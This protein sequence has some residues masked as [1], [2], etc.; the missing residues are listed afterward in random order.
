MRGGQAVMVA[1]GAVLLALPAPA[2]NG[3]RNVV[4]QRWET[5]ADGPMGG[6][7]VDM[8]NP[9]DPAERVARRPGA[10]SRARLRREPPPWFKMLQDHHLLPANQQFPALAPTAVMRQNGRL[11]LPNLDGGRQA[12]TLGNPN[13][14]L[15]FDFTPPAGDP[16]AH[17]WSATQQQA[18]SQF[19]TDIEAVCLR[20]YGPPAYNNTVKVVHDTSLSGLN[21][22][23]YD[24]T[25][26]EIRQELLFDVDFDDVTQSPVDP[27]DLYVLTLTV[28]KAY[29][30]DT[31]L[32]YEVW[33]DGLARAA[34]LLVISQARPE[35]SSYLGTGQSN[36]ARVMREALGVVRASLAQCAWLKVYAENPDVF[37][38][39]N[40]AYYSRFN[41]GLRGNVPILRSLIRAAVPQVEGF[42]FDD[43]YR[44]Q[45]VFDTAVVPGAKL[46]VF[47]HP[48]KDF[49]SFNQP[50]N[51]LPMNIYHFQV[52]SAN[53]ELPLGGQADIDYTA[54]DGVSLNNAVEGAN[55]PGALHTGIGEAGNTAG[56]GSV[57]PLFFN[58]AGDQQ[59]QMQRI[60]VLVSVNGLQRLIWYPND[61][62]LDDTAA[63]NHLA[64]L[65]TNGFQGT[66]DIAIE[67]KAP[68]QAQ[69]IQGAFK[70]KVPGGLPVP[71]RATLTWTPDTS[72]GSQGDAIVRNVMFL[73]PNGSGVDVAQGQAVLI[74]DTPPET[75]Q[76]LHQ[77]VAA[78]L[79]MITIPAFA[80]RGNEAGVLG[81]S[82]DQ[83]LMARAD[84]AVTTFQSYR[85]GSI[86]RLFPD[87]PAFRPGYAYWVKARS[88]LT[89]DFQG[90]TAN[91][92]RP[93]RQFFPPGW[94]QFGNPF[95]DLNLRLSTLQV[96][97]VD[98]QAPLTL[99]DA[100][101]QGLVSSGIFRYDTAS[102]G[103]QILDPDA[104]L[105]PFEGFWIDV[106]TDPG[107]TII[108]P[109]QVG[110][111]ARA[112]PARHAGSARDWRLRLVADS[113]GRRD[114]ATLVGV[115]PG[116]G[117]EF[118][119]QDMPKPP[120][121]G[122]A[123]SLSVP[124]V[125]WPGDGRAAADIREADGRA[126]TWDLLVESTGG[127]SDVTLSWPDLSAVPADVGLVLTDLESGQA[128]W[129]RSAGSYRCQLDADG[130]RRL[131]LTA[132]RASTNALQIARLDVVQTRGGG[133][134]SYTLTGPAE[135]TVRLTS[136]TG[137]V[138]RSLTSGRAAPGG[139]DQVAFTPTDGQGRPLPNGLY[140]IEMIATSADGRQVRATRLVLVER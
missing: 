52:S 53:E 42:G 133:S 38:T 137:Q 82:A 20:V 73:G 70:V 130:T 103:Y 122:P 63:V 108:F 138:L 94:Q 59:V 60:E 43:W 6:L 31:F 121:F 62:V 7:V 57:D 19:L 65:V 114:A 15:T 112:R 89:L 127:A 129:L 33:E 77:N 119:P 110:A 90:V 34:Q 2:E 125:G 134:V 80:G 47:N 97:A 25:N 71:A 113:G 88:A 5:V 12:G 41:G 98:G 72:G 95:S 131:R 39:F 4:N 79:R 84:G 36:D 24:S 106:L 18:L 115:A 40:Q 44:R 116:A 136:P 67:G 83:L 105:T 68:L 135:V 76:A 45:Y 87:V 16:T 92:D 99:A 10:G 48:Q 54:Y 124:H 9:A 49:D 91:R 117:D 74:L 30:D 32:F 35:S 56:L 118:T 13:N 1:L 109:N 27:Y 123:V 132:Q 28:L 61:V 120:P 11:V 46:Y 81:V 23:E 93:F 55:G 64:G 111:G 17:P 29:H 86:Y 128:R 107:V 14:R 21:M 139:N 22:A 126:K 8:N 78:G 37:K 102:G 96:Q 69:V 104:V 85:R 75:F 50:N 140:R 100:Q 58:I 51:S 26:N 101:A 66:L 3:Y